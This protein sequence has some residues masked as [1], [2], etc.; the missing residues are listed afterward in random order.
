MAD[1]GCDCIGDTHLQIVSES[2]GEI[3]AENDDHC[4]KCSMTSY[5]I[6]KEGCRNY[7]IIQ[8]CDTHS[9]VDGTLV[10]GGSTILN[11]VVVPTTAPTPSP[12]Q[13]SGQVKF[14]IKVLLEGVLSSPLDKKGRLSVEL[15]S[16]II[17]GI[18][19]TA[20][21][22][23]DFIQLSA[24]GRRMLMGADVSSYSI[25]SILG[26]T[27]NTDDFSEY[28]YNG[29]LLFEA[30]SSLLVTAVD[31]GSYSYHLQN[32]ATEISASSTA[33]ATVAEVNV[34]IGLSN[35]DSEENNDNGFPLH[36][37]YYAG[38]SFIFFF[39][40]CYC[41]RKICCR[42]D[43]TSGTS[44]PR[45]EFHHVSTDLAPSAPPLQSRMVKHMAAEDISISLGANNDMV[46]S[47]DIGRLVVMTVI[48]V[49]YI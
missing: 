13:S 48:F 30:L 23:L 39:A 24:H 31:S 4:N 19:P 22:Y 26:V 35:T 20:I 28:Q 8:T 14:T 21:R 41:S 47:N 42:D 18:S 32:K 12:T 38:A 34:T 11:G 7:C 17:M 49:F 9:V 5:E 33:S 29:N 45:T 36:L 1:L 44:R 46:S 25:I 3:L 15:A 27:L 37:V 10:C 43:G 6:D 16:A 40:V 2:T